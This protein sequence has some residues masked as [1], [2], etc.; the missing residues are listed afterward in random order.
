[1][2]DKTEIIKKR[3]VELEQRQLAI[4]E[5]LKKIIQYINT[6]IYK[7]YKAYSQNEGGDKA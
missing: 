6:D 7:T 5:M 4:K 3:M 2:E 1:M